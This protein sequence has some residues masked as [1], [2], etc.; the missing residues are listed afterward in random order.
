MMVTVA[1]AA[2]AITGLDWVHAV[3]SLPS[4]DS[5]DMQAWINRQHNTTDQ[6]DHT[7]VT[8]N[9]VYPD[10]LRPLPHRQ[11]CVPPIE[12]A[13]FTALLTERERHTTTTRTARDMLG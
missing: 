12:Y 6:P 1:E 9:D 4:I 8:P 2:I 7:V 3:A 11:I 5:P 10:R 13:T